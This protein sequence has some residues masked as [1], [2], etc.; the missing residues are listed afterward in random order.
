[1]EGFPDFK[2]RATDQRSGKLSP[3]RPAFFNVKTGCLCK[4]QTDL[5]PLGPRTTAGARPTAASSR[6][7]LP[8]LNAAAVVQAE[9]SYSMSCAE[10]QTRYPGT[11]RTR[12]TPQKRVLQNRRT[13]VF[14]AR[15]TQT[16]PPGR[17]RSARRPAGSRLCLFCGSL[18]PAARQAFFLSAPYLLK[19]FERGWGVG[20]GGN[21]F[22]SFPLP[23]L[24]SLSPNPS[25]AAHLT[26]TMR[27]L[28]GAERGS[29]TRR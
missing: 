23:P 17:E 13:R 27:P 11:D 24:S 22:K 10:R 6:N 2:K 9:G 1:M 12:F 16:I 7:S 25:S 3:V 5:S 21:F 15:K 8:A 29:W 26:L 20:E 4:S 28:R 14:H 19:S 18:P